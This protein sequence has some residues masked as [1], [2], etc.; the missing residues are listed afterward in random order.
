MSK[1]T[2]F[3]ADGTEEVECLTIV[4][5]LRRAG[6]EVDL[7]S[8]KD[9]KTIVSSHKVTIV[10][11]KTFDEAD[12]EGS[13]M[14][15]IPGGMPGVL[16]MTEHEG[17]AR[18]I[19]AHAVKGKKLA[20]VCAGPSVIGRLGLL[21]GKKA[22]CFPGWEEKLEGAIVTSEGVVTDGDITTGKGLGYSVDLGIELIRILVDEETALDIKAR[23][24]HP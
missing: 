20:A 17:L 1:V 23:I 6:V 4:D 7:V 9:D 3:I 22:T 14:L 15:F 2:V 5:L 13:D 8:I 21:E 16:N 10:A 24:Q 18:A 11:D 12:L 19:S